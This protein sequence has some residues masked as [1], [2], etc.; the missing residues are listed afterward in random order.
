[1][2]REHSGE[3]KVMSFFKNSPDMNTIGTFVLLGYHLAMCGIVETVGNTDI[4]EGNLKLILGLIWSLILRYQIGRTNFPPKKLMLSWLQAALPDLHISNFTSDW[5]SGIALSVENC[6][7]AMHAARDEFS[8]PMILTPED[9]ASHNLDELSGMTYLSYFMKDDSPGYKSTLS[10]VQKK[11]P[12]F[13]I[14]NFTTDWND[15]L[16]LCALVKAYGANVPDYTELKKDRSF[17]EQNIQHEIVAQK[18]C[19][20]ATRQCKTEHYAV[21][22]VENIH[23]LGWELL[24]HPPYLPDIAPSDFHLFRF[25]QHFLRTLAEN[26]HAF[27]QLQPKRIDLSEVLTACT[28]S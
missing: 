24:F 22:T 6:R 13:N 5:N 17:W 28:V 7:T 18:R 15:G 2:V 23:E 11:L 10:W 14:R 9:L 4:V 3:F 20:S 16:A 26:L 1:M 27:M 12:Q 25:L 19:Y 8:V 21:Q